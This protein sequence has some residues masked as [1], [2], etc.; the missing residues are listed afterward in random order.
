MLW[1]EKKKF[2]ILKLTF[3]LGQTKASPLVLI[4]V[5]M[6]PSDALKVMHVCFRSDAAALRQLRS[7]NAIERPGVLRGDASGREPSE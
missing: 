6:S 7:V 3:Q 5:I 1:E 2:S 4:V